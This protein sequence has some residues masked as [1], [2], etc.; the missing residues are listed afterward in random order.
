MKRFILLLFVLLSIGVVSVS[1]Q[2][3]F[4]WNG[5]DRFT[6]LIMGIDRR[7]SEGGS[8][9]F[10]SD[11][12]MLASVNPL[13]NRAG[14]LSIPRTIH[15][16]LADTGE[17]VPVH[18]LLVRG[19]VRQEGYGPEL[20]RQTIQHN[21]GIYI[22]AYVL[23]DFNGFISLVDAI[24][25]IEISL[26][27]QIND[28]T[29]PDMNYGYDPFYLSAGT[30]ILNGYDALRFART[31]HNDNDYLRVERQLQVIRAIRDRLSDPAVLQHMITQAPQLM[32]QLSNNLISN[33]KPQDA[34]YVGL[35]LMN[36]TEDNI[37]FGSL[38]EEYSFFYGTTSG[39]VRVPDRTRLSELLLN[40]FGE[41]Y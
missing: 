12:I 21:L 37:S 14:V 29:Y 1:A 24:G 26:N 33:L 23:V 34:I 38:N 4:N 28:S 19:E 35:S 41:G 13:N 6:V 18:T 40:V 10:R 11:T 15:L 16:A 25:G 8:L 5:T 3:D 22:D 17:L 20:V 36:I 31:R 32:S 2:D 30:H 9:T 39:T 7:P 27:Y